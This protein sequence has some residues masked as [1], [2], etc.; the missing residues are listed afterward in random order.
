[1]AVICLDED[2]L[3]KIAA[4]VAG[5]LGAEKAARVTY[6]QPDHFIAQLKPLAQAPP[7]AE[8]PPEKRRGY[9]VKRTVS[10]LSPEEQKQREQ[11]GIRSIAEAMRRKAG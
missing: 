8:K 6:L 3:R 10:K 5:S 9:I 11:A 4:A 1:V 2:R 7:E